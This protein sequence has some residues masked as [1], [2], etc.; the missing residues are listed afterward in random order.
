MIVYRIITGMIGVNTYIVANEKTNECIIIDAGGDYNKIMSKIKGFSLNPKGVLLT[1]GH[2]DHIGAVAQLQ[3]DGLKVYL[4]QADDGF[5]VNPRS[6]GFPEF[7]KYITP[8]KTDV[9]VNDN[10]VICLAGLEIKVITT[11]GH[12]LGGVTYLIEDSL[13]TGDTLFHLSIGR[14]D[15]EGGDYKTLISSIKNKLFTY[16]DKKVYPGHEEMTDIDYEKN[17]NPYCGNLRGGFD[18]I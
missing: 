4:N 2:F 17:Y 10:D 12:T 3:K 9:F 15:L 1:H 7:A 14:T 13:F 16:T 5:T 11:P 6:G 8:F 18:D